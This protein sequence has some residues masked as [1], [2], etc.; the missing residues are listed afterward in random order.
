MTVRADAVERT[1]ERIIDA[2]L[3]RYADLPYDRIRLED[4]AADAGVTVQTVIRRFGSKHG[5]LAATVQREFTRL[6]ADRA[7]AMGEDPEST[8]RALVR[9]YEHHGA[10]ILKLYAEAHQAPGVPELAARGRAYHL[11]WC[12]EAFSGALERVEDIDAR[13]RRLAQVVA[14]CDAA[15]WRILRFDGELSQHQTEEALLEMLLPLVG[16]GSAQPVPRGSA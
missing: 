12:R 5:L 13:T 1:G 8:L 14:I 9:Y 2:M 3:R 10:L 15:T 7:A 6:A 4:V 16:P 11:T